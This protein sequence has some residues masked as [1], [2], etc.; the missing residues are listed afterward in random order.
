[1]PFPSGQS[2]DKMWVLLL[3]LLHMEM[4]TSGGDMQAPNPAKG[5][6]EWWIWVVIIV[7]VVAAALYFI[8][9]RTPE[10]VTDDGKTV[11]Q[12]D[13]PLSVTPASTLEAVPEGSIFGMDWEV[14]A[15]MET[16]VDET[17][18]F[19]AL[20]SVEVGEGVSPEDA[21][22]EDRAVGFF[23]EPVPAMFEENIQSPKGIIGE[24]IYMR[25]YARIG[26]NHYWGDEV[27][28]RIKEVP[29]VMD[30]EVK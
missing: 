29:E 9:E 12:V 23:S 16:I 17:T 4:N 30:E 22:Y 14:E 13:V 28:V 10:D 3:T 24:T 19:W 11:E 1:M 18:V 21:G 20:E 25:T 2:L 5:G 7:L 15:E 8:Q 26:E 27:E 6:K